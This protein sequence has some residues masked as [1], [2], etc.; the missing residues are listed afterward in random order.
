MEYN[1]DTFMLYM[2]IRTY[3]ILNIPVLNLNVIFS[4][5]LEVCVESRNWASVYKPWYR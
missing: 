5:D 3:V 2:C 1:Y 4:S